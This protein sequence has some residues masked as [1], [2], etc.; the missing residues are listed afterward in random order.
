MSDKTDTIKPSEGMDRSVYGKFIAWAKGDKAQTVA[1]LLLILGSLIY[2]VWQDPEQLEFVKIIAILF[3]G[4]A[5][6]EEFF[7]LKGKNVDLEKDKVSLEKEKVNLERDK[8]KD[9]INLERDK[10]TLST[11]VMKTEKGLQARFIKNKHSFHYE[12]IGLFLNK[13]A[14]YLDGEELNSSVIKSYKEMIGSILDKSKKYAG[15]IT[16]EYKEFLDKMLDERE[17][18][19]VPISEFSKMMITDKLT[20][21]LESN[22]KDNVNENKE[23]IEDFNKDHTEEN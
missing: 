1:A 15:M 13:I 22:Y 11:T 2:Q 9:K 14:D 6:V 10:L 16:N 7:E 21:S 4:T 8:E 20:Q 19:D 3:I 12:V 17:Q 23:A 5:I 18:N